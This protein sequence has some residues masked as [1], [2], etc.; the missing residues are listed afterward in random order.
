[1]SIISDAKAGWRTKLCYDI[2]HESGDWGFGSRMGDQKT[3]PT[4]E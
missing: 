4:A 1:M 3:P 2:N